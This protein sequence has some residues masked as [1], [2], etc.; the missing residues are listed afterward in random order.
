MKITR[1]KI[2]CVI[3]L[4]PLA[5]AA[6][7]PA[8]YYSA[9]YGKSGAAL[10]TV[11]HGKIKGHTVRTY[12][13]LWTDFVRTDSRADGT[14]W[15]MY[16]NCNFTWGT[17]GNQDYGSGGSAEC[18]FYNREHSFPK[19]WFGIKGGD[20][21]DHPMGT[22]LFHLIPSD[23]RVNTGRSNMPYGEVGTTVEKNY[24]NGSKIGAC[25]FAGCT[26]KVFEPIDEYKGDFARTYFYV[27]TRYEN[28]V[29]NWYATAEAPKVID[30][31]SYPAFSAWAKEM[32]LK[33]HRQDTVSAKEIARNDSIYKIQK[34]RN[35]FIDHPEFAE[36]IWGDSMS[37]TW[38]G[39]GVYT[40][41]PKL[42]EAS[43]TLYPNPVTNG[44]LTCDMRY[45]KREKESQVENRRSQ[46]E[47]YSLS[48]AL[49]ATYKI[50]GEEKMRI[51]V[52]QLPNGAYLLK[53][54]KSV[55]R[56]VKQ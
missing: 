52:S 13:E 7:E 2:A 46:I 6:Q 51:D 54:G 35:P 49:V 22:D 19:S 39:G 25:S 12:R 14:V 56:F 37:Y 53:V 17:S 34:N 24:L 18:Q 43:F 8:D 10:K 42:A 48:G 36:Y 27:V 32:L 45:A 3:L 40:A 44:E 33:W 47:I 11:L 31:T 1:I 55:V 28:E 5:A 4:L 29:A 38:N 41:A 9:A 15:D 23:K 21:D 50:T 30:G 26:G 16:S 20:E